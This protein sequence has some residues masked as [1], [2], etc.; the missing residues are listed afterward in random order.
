M[1]ATPESRVCLPPPPAQQPPPG[2]GGAG[3]HHIA[4][5]VVYLLVGL[6]LSIRYLVH[7]AVFRGHFAAFRAL[8]SLSAHI[9]LH[10]ADLF[11]HFTVLLEM[12]SP[13]R[14][15]KHPL[16]VPPSARKLAPAAYW[17]VPGHPHAPESARLAAKKGTQPTHPGRKPADGGQRDAGPCGPALPRRRSVPPFPCTQ[18]PA[19]YGAAG[20]HATHPP[21]PL[22]AVRKCGPWRQPLR[23]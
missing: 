3:G 22:R 16:T 5:G 2:G 10:L 11:R 1:P 9:A 12:R 23:V 17:H 4:V 21:A 6:Y 13:L 8:I 15:S 20:K 14:R 18:F 7:P 19:P